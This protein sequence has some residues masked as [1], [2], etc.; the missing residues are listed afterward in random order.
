MKPVQPRL[1]I[2]IGDPAGIGPEI[3]VKALAQRT[4][5]EFAIPVVV[6]DLAVLDEAMTI[7]GA[8]LSLRRR[9]LGDSFDDDR[10]AIDVIDLRNV[11]LAGLRRA[12]VSAAAGRAAREYLEVA[13]QLALSG[14]VVGVVTA[15]LNKEAL[16]MAGW[17]GVG[18]T[19]LLAGFCGVARS[20]VAMMLASDRLRVVHVSTH[21]PLSRAVQL[22]E[23]DRIVRTTKL[24][25]A[26]TS[27]IVD[28]PP[29]IAIAG[30]NPHAGEH[31]LFGSEDEE[32]IVPA[33]EVL[34]TE[35]FDVAGPISPDTV[36]M[37]AIEGH[38]D[39]V[40]AMYH[41]QGH[42]PAKLA[43]LSETVN[44]TLGLPIIRTSVDHGTAFDIAGTGTADATNLV[45]AYRLAARMA[46]HRSAAAASLA[47]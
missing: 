18:H 3:V 20:A 13:T 24:A 23:T 27:E 15:P 22:V 41:D 7:A 38:F 28:R 29:R 19:E 33:V 1:A 17:P 45:V 2:T 34:R 8:R 6:G 40:I 37:R 12:E 39:V 42:I 16:A 5:A 32:Q 43:G 14:S 25:A 9:E 11:E 44:V 10:S 4:L 46:A 35:G 26:A 36:F 21:V 30:L 31:G 47:G